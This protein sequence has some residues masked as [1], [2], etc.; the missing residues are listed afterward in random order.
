M[1]HVVARL[2]DLER[3]ADAQDRADAVVEGLAD[4]GADEFVGLLVVLAALGVPHHHVGTAQLGQHGAGDLT[5]VG[6]GRVRRHVLCAVADL[7]L[8][9]VDQRLDAADVDE[10]RHDDG[11]DGLEL[12]GREAEGELLHQ[13]DRLEVVE[14]HLPVAG[15]QRLASLTH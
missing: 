2:A 7:E 9:A 15:D 12:L 5:G 11:L 13:R 14:V 4:L 1:R 10:R 8:V 6:A 3:L